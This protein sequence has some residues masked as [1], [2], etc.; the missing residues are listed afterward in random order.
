LWTA[1]RLHTV[2]QDTLEEAIR[3]K[4][5]NLNEDGNLIQEKENIR[6]VAFLALQDNNSDTV[7]FGFTLLARTQLSQVPQCAH[8][9]LNSPDPE[10]RVGFINTALTFRDIHTVPML[11]TRL[12]F[13]QDGKVIWW[14]LKTLAIL[15]PEQVISQAQ[16]FLKHHDPLVRAGGVV[17]LLSSGN[18][19]QVIE[20][21][22]TLNVM[23][24]HPNAAMRKGA[25]Y[26]ISAVK[27]G[28][29]ENELRALLEDADELVNIAAMWAV[30][31]QNNVNLAS[32]LT[33]KLGH[34]RVSHYAGRTL[35]R[36]GEAALPHLLD[37][38]RTAELDG[39]GQSAARAA[40]R[41]LVNIR[42][43][44]AD[45]VL[46][47]AVRCGGILTRSHI[48]KECAMRAKYKPNS[49]FLIHEARQ[50]MFEEAYHVRIFNAAQLA[51]HLPEHIRLEIAHRSLMAQARLLYWF[52]VY[53]QS[54]ELIGIIP[55]ILNDKSSQKN[56]M[57]YATAIEFLDTLTRDKAVKKAL[58]VFEENIEPSD[59]DA[60]LEKLPQI[61]DAWLAQIYHT[62]L[63][64]CTGGTMDITHKVM[65]LR[66]V[67]LFAN[68]PGEI[69]LTIAESCEDRE[70]V[71]G[72]KLMSQGDAPDGLYI[73]VSG[74]V[75]IEKNGICLAELMEGNF[76]GE[77][78]LFDDAP[79]KADAIVRI[80]GMVLFLEKEVFD[81]LT[82]DL[83]EVLRALI[84]TVI[85]YIK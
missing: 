75:S 78:G 50:W 13:E 29:L 24:K 84:K 9:H 85:S 69:L 30:A 81:G 60:A 37:I 12:T 23:L 39:R 66:K 67:K 73:I 53:T 83:P 18:L 21:A 41:V 77:L 82:E 44:A 2:Y 58:S 40:V 74:M 52:D 59:I 55:V 80:D 43:E 68:L 11:L 34:G 76:F 16:A 42:T 7:R 45:K 8:P 79:R 35:R 27:I 19:E 36:I 10:L 62:Q 61:E 14:L 72:E 28:K 5:F 32:A 20:A 64:P 22:N 6:Q 70:V 46:I 51:P 65:L 3:I 57:Q 63:L 47:E 25:A 33:A 31:D 56:V 38:I 15:A 48:A 1:Q 4:R 54:V 17:V 71:R 49:N 26:A